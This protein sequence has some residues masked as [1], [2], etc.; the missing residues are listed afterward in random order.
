MHIAIIPLRKGSKGIPGKNKKKLLGRPL[1]AW[2]LYEAMKSDLEKVYIYT[3]DEE[4]IEYVNREYHWSNKVTCMTRSEKSASDNA[5]TEFA[6]EEFVSKINYKFDTLSL[7]QATSP[8]LMK[9]DINNCLKAVEEEGFDSS[10][11]VSPMK[12]FFW[13][14]DGTPVNYDYMKRERRQDME[15]DLVENGACYTTSNECYNES[16][17]RISGNI[18]P[19]IMSEESIF[20]IDEPSDFIV[21]ENLLKN[22]LK[23][24]NKSNQPFK[25]VA[26]DVDGVFTDCK[27]DYNKNGEHTKKFSMRDGMGLELLRN[28]GIEVVVITS[29]NSQIVEQRMKKLKISNLFMG[30][31]DKYSKLDS[32]LTKKGLSWSELAY[33][34]DDINDLTNIIASGKSFTPNDANL[35]ILL[36]ADF[37]LKNKGGNG[38]IREMVEVIIKN[39][40]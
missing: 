30:V 8:L 28:E 9:E 19:I 38:A 21:I 4:I 37:V 12:R 7:I 29:E 22:R 10:I 33:I 13:N 1:F 26:L 6:M 40:I 20:E 17:N 15:F 2:T 23:K 24:E 3:D 35:N 11:T 32:F 25:V 36:N 14:Y 5:S 16:K 27:V 18:K 39:Y 34:G 31:K